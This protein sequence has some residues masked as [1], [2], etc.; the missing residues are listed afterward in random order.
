[1]ASTAQFGAKDWRKSAYGEEQVLCKVRKPK[2][3]NSISLARS[4]DISFAFSFPLC[5]LLICEFPTDSSVVG[6]STSL[7]P[8]SQRSV[9]EKVSRVAQYIYQK[10]VRRK[11]VPFQP[12][13]KEPKY[14]LCYVEEELEC[15]HK[16]E[17]YPGDSETLTARTRSCHECAGWFGGLKLPP[18][19][20]PNASILRSYERIKK[21]AGKTSWWALIFA[22]GTLG[23]FAL[24]VLTHIP[25]VYVYQAPADTLQI[26]GKVDPFHYRMRQIHSGP[27]FS[28][29]FSATF[30]SNYSPMFSEGETLTWLA[31]ED[32]GKCWS[33]SSK[34]LGYTFLRDAEGN[35]KLA[36]N[37]YWK[38]DVLAT[39]K[40]EPKW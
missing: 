2:P 25:K 20:K 13:P 17:V 30:C 24:I 9:A 38:D 23:L 5:D 36:P 35:V 12:S 3:L 16:I 15:G 11:P 28:R 10:V 8:E 1:M 32:R 19:K 6:L 34:V 33:V 4:G 26:L 31:Y 7:V 39:C 29:E 22:G 21:Q 37:C 14:L 40:G 27:S 18:G